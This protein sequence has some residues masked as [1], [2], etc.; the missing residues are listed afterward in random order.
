MT[1]VE[2]VVTSSIFNMSSY[3]NQFM[4]S[5][6]LL[7]VI[8]KFPERI[9]N[10]TG[11]LSISV[12]MYPPPPPPIALP[13]PPSRGA[14]GCSLRM[15]FLKFNI[16]VYFDTPAVSKFAYVQPRMVWLLP[17][18]HKQHRKCTADVTTIAHFRLHY[19]VLL[20]IDDC[21]NI[22]LNKK[23]M[24]SYFTQKWFVTCISG[25][26]CIVCHSKNNTMCT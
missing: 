15:I 11:P 14:L 2:P 20:A 21:T 13:P 3:I 8:V 12:N 26:L 25:L 1:Y 9:K 16:F 18:I 4:S 23:Y 5:I 19:T 10:I 24:Q 7:R 17:W 6:L 22:L